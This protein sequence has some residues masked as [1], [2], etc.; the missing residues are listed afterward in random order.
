MPQ[1]QVAVLAADRP[2]GS[3][4][5]SVLDT[6][7]G[8]RYDFGQTSGM[9]GG[10]TMKLFL[11]E[12][13]LLREQDLGLGPDTADALLAPMIENSDN[14]SAD[15]IY[16]LISGGSGA[17]AALGRLG[18][19]DT[20]LDPDG[21][22]GLSTTS[23][24]DQVTLLGHL[25]SEDSPLTESSRSYALSLMRDV[26]SDQR[27]G[28]GSTADAGTTFANKNGW[29]AVDAD[30]DRWLVNSDG[31]VTSHG[32]VLLI[33]V[34]TQHNDSFDDGVSLTEQLA[35]AAVARLEG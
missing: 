14:A 4:S 35:Q 8:A 23:A 15:A 19:E 16:S 12:A 32:H 22:W 25:V 21:E 17:N 9:T 30:D 20:V 2:P 24:R 7:T 29:L 31:V 1:D 13:E 6:T 34:L 18:L 10:S 27:W 11:L 28:V 5:V 3:V 26:E 33:C